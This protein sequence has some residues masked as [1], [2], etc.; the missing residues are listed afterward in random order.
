[1]ATAHNLT[2][3]VA[4]AEN[5]VGVL[6]VPAWSGLDW[7]WHGF[8]THWGGVSRVYLPEGLRDCAE[9]DRR[10]QDC[11]GLGQLNLGFTA[12]DTAENVCENRLR[13]IEAVSGSRATP[14][15]T[16]RQVHSC[17]SVAADTVVPAAIPEADGI[18]TAQCGLLI[19]VQTA[20][21]I[22]VL[23]VDPERRAVGAFHAGWRGTVA[24]IVEL[25]V[26]RMERNFGSKPAQLM[27]AIGSGIGACCY[28]VGGEVRSRFE[29]NFSYAEELFTRSENDLRLDLV[30]A[31]RRQL[32]AAGLAAGSIAV[33]GGCTSCQP[34]LFFSHRASGGHAG[35]MMAVIG[36]R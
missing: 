20:D 25:G 17:I 26:G 33:V 19:G 32:L 5:G 2:A 16:L 18:M 36:I 29:A 23:V 7:L 10:D 35:R 27:A 6:V 22:P 11:V 9:Q 21:C 31:N 3:S 24:R 28:T 12:A 13:F 34:E 30:E 15:R 1:M 8:S 4:C 14:L